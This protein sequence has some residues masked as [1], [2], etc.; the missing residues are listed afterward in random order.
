MQVLT[1]KECAIRLKVD[2]PQMVTISFREGHGS[3]E[4]MTGFLP[5]AQDKALWLTGLIQ[6]LKWV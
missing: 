6:V 4:G 2:V 3:L 5:V 1:F